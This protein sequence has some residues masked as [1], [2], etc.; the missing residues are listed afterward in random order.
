MSNFIQLKNVEVDGK[1][2]QQVINKKGV[3]LGWISYYPK[4]QKYVYST[5]GATE[6]ILDEGCL[7][8]IA[9]YVRTSNKYKNF[10]KENA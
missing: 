4:W 1:E 3:H 7:E 10:D 2:I 6:V 8:E 5:H 9:S